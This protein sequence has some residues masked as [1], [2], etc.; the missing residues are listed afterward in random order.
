M[1]KVVQV[2]PI[3]GLLAWCVI[4][5]TLPPESDQKWRHWPSTLWV[6]LATLILTAVAF[7]SLPEWSV[8]WR[9]FGGL[10]V[11]G[12]V[13]LSVWRSWAE[14][15]EIH[16][17]LDKLHDPFRSDVK[18]RATRISA[19]L[20]A[21]YNLLLYASNKFD[22]PWRSKSFE[23]EADFAELFL[24][25]RTEIDRLVRDLETC[26]LVVPMNVKEL[27]SDYLVGT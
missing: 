19:P 20:I 2:L 13:V 7:L 24:N 6:G 1:D 8:L 21:R 16:A 25:E 18:A 5:A 10:I 3:V 9:I 17:K 23:I 27:A 26:G 11:V 22:E 12:F 14:S 15:K 4:V